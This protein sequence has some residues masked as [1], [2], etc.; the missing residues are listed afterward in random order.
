[1]YKSLVFRSRHLHSTVPKV[2]EQ[3]VELPLTC[4]GNLQRVRHLTIV[5]VKILDAPVVSGALERLP[6]LNHYVRRLSYISFP[7]TSCH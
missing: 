3:L 2:S 1:M 6:Q 7:V 5:C 4:P